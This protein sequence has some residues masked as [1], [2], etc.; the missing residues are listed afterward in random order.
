M[1]Y[2]DLFASAFVHRWALVRSLWVSG[3]RVLVYNPL[4]FVTVTYQPR[5]LHYCHK[6]ALSTIIH[7]EWAEVVMAVVAQQNHNVIPAGRKE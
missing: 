1:N 2:Y 6:S 4:E 5:Y 7:N 3:R